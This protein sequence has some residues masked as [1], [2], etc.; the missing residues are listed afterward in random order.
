MIKEHWPLKSLEETAALSVWADSGA[1]R[2]QAGRLAERLGLPMV[3]GQ[4]AHGLALRF[5]A[6]GLELRCTRS[7]ADVLCLRGDFTRMLPRLQPG[8]LQRELLVRAARIR[9]PTGRLVAID[10]TA[11]L[12]EDAMLLA[13]AGF[14]VQL[15]ES[16]PVIAA[17]LADALDRAAG[18]PALAPVV[19]RMQLHETDSLTALPKLPAPPDVIL[20]DPMFPARH[21]SAL[22]KK[23]LQLLQMLAC[24]CA[25]EAAL[26][27]AAIAA[28]PRK[29][30]IKR[31][32]KG[33]CL[34][35]IKAS[36][37]FTGRAI[38]I[39]CLVLPNPQT[40]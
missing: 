15:Y 29:V 9:R 32:L 35:G 8:S 27:M 26:L 17:L 12:G 33:A 11:G 37:S 1:D 21:K 24:P 14:S 36:H 6:H 23:K 38:R 28:R 18:V 22:V 16:N 34:A 19:S 31:P 2:I 40:H 20:L 5:G 4:P 39:D 25:D 13:A 7:G 10:A 3:Q 30:L